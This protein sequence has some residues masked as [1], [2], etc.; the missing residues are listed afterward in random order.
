MVEAAR[1][2]EKLLLGADVERKRARIGSMR[3]LLGKESG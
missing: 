3:A 1:D 2:T